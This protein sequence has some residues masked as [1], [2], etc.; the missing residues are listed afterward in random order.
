MTFHAEH[1]TVHCTG[2]VILVTL[3]CLTLF[4][5]GCAS[6]SLVNQWKNPAVP[7]RPYQKLLVVGIANDITIRRAYENILTEDLQK[8]GVQAVSS[9]TY[10]PQDVKPDKEQVKAVVKECGADGVITSRV[11]GVKDDDLFVSQYGF[12]FDPVTGPPMEGMD[13]YSFYGG[14]AVAPVIQDLQS[15]IL[16]TRLFDVPRATLVWVASTTSFDTDRQFKTIHDLANLIAA[17]LR[18]EG[19]LKSAP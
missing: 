4:L 6:T 19:Y 16:E 17:T 8:L 14:I 11:V 3:L 13:L 12:G 2:R 10:L 18:K 5:G 7:P 9:I 1:G 15:A